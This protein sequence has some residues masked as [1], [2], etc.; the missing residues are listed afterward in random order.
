MAIVF[1]VIAVVALVGAAA[2][3]VWYSKHWRQVSLGPE[4]DASSRKF[5]R[6]RHVD[7]ERRRR[8]RHRDGVHLR[9]VHARDRRYYARTWEHLQSEFADNPSLALHGAEH[10]VM[11]VLRTRGYP[12][13]EA[14]EQLAL[15]APEYA[16]SL[17]D[18]R[19]AQQTGRRA[20]EDPTSVPAEELRRAMTSYHAL[21]NELVED[22]GTKTAQSVEAGGAR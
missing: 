11:S 16:D 6:R 1:T 17:A 22:P 12:G 9:T 19:T 18:F 8:R 13:G 4:L 3:W 21:F 2:L 20:G 15:L 7:R 10:L 14:Q 5:D